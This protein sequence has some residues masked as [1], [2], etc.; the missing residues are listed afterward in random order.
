[1]TAKS[2]P[3]N[4]LTAAEQEALSGL[5]DF[6]DGQQLEYLSL[7]ET[8]LALA[9]SRHSFY[10]QVYCVLQIGYFKAKR[11]FFRFDW[12]GVE[13]DC[14]FVLSRHFHGEA[15]DTL[16]SYE[17][18]MIHPVGQVDLQVI[19]DEKPNI[20]RIV[21]L[22]G[23]KE[24]TQG[25][26]IRKLCTYTTPNPTWRAIFEFDKLIRSIY[27]LRYLRDPQ[28]ERTVHS[29][30]NRIESYHQRRSAIAP[31][32]GKKE[33]AGRT[34]IE[35]EISN[36]CGRLIANAIIYRNSAILSRLLTWYEASGIRRH[37]TLPDGAGVVAS[38]ISLA[39][40]VTHGRRGRLNRAAARASRVRDRP[41]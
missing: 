5:P 24:M 34:D 33:L 21:A 32:G 6:D 31:V 17:K 35:L 9:T 7:S 38:A 18:C 20:D 19:I 11:A 40:R 26:L 14:T 28:L 36:Q 10:A 37:E 12:S 22:L 23:L 2:E 15:F 4:V 16:A 3:L 41:R 29:S 27:T 39:S 30:Q 8:E 13:N 1:V 25:T